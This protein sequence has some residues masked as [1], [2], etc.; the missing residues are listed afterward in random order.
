MIEFC[1]LFWHLAI[2]PNHSIIYRLS[3]EIKGLWNL[4]IPGYNL[5][6]SLVLENQLFLNHGLSCSCLVFPIPLTFPLILEACLHLHSSCSPVNLNILLPYFLYLEHNLIFQGPVQAP[7][8]LEGFPCPLS[9]PDKLDCFLFWSLLEIT[10]NP[11]TSPDAFFE[12]ALCGKE[13]A[14]SGASGD[15]GFIPELE[16]FLGR[17]LGNPV[18]YSCLEIS[19]DRGVWR[20]TICRVAKSQTRLKQLS[21]HAHTCGH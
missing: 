8:S 1:W 19:M 10:S 17:G 14:C 18:W 5:W 21:M 7:L 11:L 12:E 3:L 6:F 9:N 20:A 16:R 2:S 13:S 15:M 4:D